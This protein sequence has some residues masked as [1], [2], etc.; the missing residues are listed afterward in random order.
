[1]RGPTASNGIVGMKP[2]H[3]L[4]SHDGIIPLSITFDMAGPMAR[5]VYDV[6]VMLGAMT[7]VDPADETTQKSEGLA[8]TDYTAFLDAGALEGARIGIAR[9]FLGAD[10]EVDWIVEAALETIQERGATIVDV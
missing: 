2:T 6:A 4:L 10:E 7:G 5:S 1:V 8:Y 3:G 9:D